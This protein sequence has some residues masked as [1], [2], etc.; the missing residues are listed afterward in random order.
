MPPEFQASLD[1]TASPACAAVYE[2][3]GLNVNYTTISKVLMNLYDS[4]YCRASDEC[5]GQAFPKQHINLDY[6]L[7]IKKLNR[8]F[9]KICVE[10]DNS[11]IFQNA[12]PYSE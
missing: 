9:S 5:Y 6:F 3:S 12:M 7:V 4:N 11:Y 10:Y 8:L 1:Y 2:Y